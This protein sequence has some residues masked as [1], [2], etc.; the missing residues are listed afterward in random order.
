MEESHQFPCW[1]HRIVIVNSKGKRNWRCD[2]VRDFDACQQYMKQI[3]LAQKAQKGSSNM[4]SAV[5]I[6]NCCTNPTQGGRKKKKQ[7]ITSAL[8][9]HYTAEKLGKLSVEERAH[10]MKLNH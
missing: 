5:N 4:I 3:L 10:V 6:N 8:T 9:K 2:K 7:K 1:Y